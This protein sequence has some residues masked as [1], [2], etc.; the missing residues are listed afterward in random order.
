MASDNSDDEAE[1]TPALIRAAKANNVEGVK[2]ALD[3]GE[4]INVRDEEYYGQ[5]AISWAAELGH[6]EV[7]KILYERDARLDILDFDGNSPI[8]WAKVENNLDVVKY[9][10]ANIK[11]RDVSHKYNHGRGLLFLAVE[12]GSV[13]DIKR[14]VGSEP[15]VVDDDGLTPLMLAASDYPNE[16]ETSKAL[17]EA[18]A[19]PLLEDNKGRTAIFYAFQWVKAELATLLLEKAGSDFNVNGS[20]PGARPLIEAAK[21]GNVTMLQQLLDRKPDVESPDEEGKTP[22]YWSAKNSHIEATCLLIDAGAKPERLCRQPIPNGDW[23]LAAFAIAAT[24]NEERWQR[25][26]RQKPDLTVRNDDNGRT[27]FHHAAY[28]GV[29]TAA[30]ERM[31]SAGYSVDAPDSYGAT[32]LMLASERGHGHLVRLLLDKHADPELAENQWD[33]TALMFAATYGH[34]DIV[35]QLIPK[36]KLDAQD[37]YKNTALH[38]AADRC[39]VESVKA[40]I[41]KDFDIVNVVDDRGESPLFRAVQHNRPEVVAALIKAGADIYLVNRRKRAAITYG[42]N[43]PAI[44]QAFIDEEKD[45]SGPEDKETP[46]VRVIEMAMRYACEDNNMRGPDPHPPIFP[47]DNEEDEKYLTAVDVTGRN[48]VSW[49]AQCGDDWEMRSLCGKKSLDFKTADKTSRTPLHWLAENQSRETVDIA[50]R[51][52]DYGVVL[53]SKDKNGRTPLSYAAE[54]GQLEL[55][56]FLITKGAEPHSED[57]KKRTVLSWAAGSGHD[58]CVQLLLSEKS[59][60][61]DSKDIDGRTPLSW[62]SGMGRIEVVKTLLAQRDGKAKSVDSKDNRGKKEKGSRVMGDE[63]V[64]I[65]S[66]DNKSQTPLWHAADNQHLTVFETLLLYGAKSNIKDTKGRTLRDYLNTKIQGTEVSE[67]QTLRAMF[68]KLN[69]SGFLWREPSGDTT[70]VDSEFSATLL[71][72]SKGDR[73]DIEIRTPTVASLLQ[74]KRPPLEAEMDCAWT[75]LPANNMRWVEVLMSKHFEASGEGWRSNVVL[76]PRLW[77]QQQHKSQDGQYHARFMRP[78][79]RSFTFPEQD[80]ADP[81]LVLFMPYLHWELEEEQRKLKDVMAKKTAAKKLKLSSDDA[82]KE[83]R[84]KLVQTALKD[85]SLCGTEKLYWAYL[86][87]EHPLHGRRTL[88]QFYYHILAD[89]EKRDKDQTSLRYFQE[90]KRALNSSESQDLRPT[91]TVVDQLW[92]WVLPECGKSPRTI[93]T[94]FP[95]RSNRMSKTSKI[96][97]SLV[98]NIFDRFREF[99]AKRSDASVD[100]L[101]KVIVAECAR[102]Y[103]DP[104]SNRNELIQFVEIYRTSI[105]EITEDETKRFQSFQDHIPS[106]DEE[107]SDAVPNQAR[108]SLE[109]SLDVASDGGSLKGSKTLAVD[110]GLDEVPKKLN[111]MIDIKAD[112]E[113]LRKIKDIRDELHIISSIFHIQKNVVETV[114]HILEDFKEKRKSA[115]SD[116]QNSWLP[117]PPRRR[118]FSPPSRRPGYSP[119]ASYPPPPRR[120]SLS[121]PFNGRGPARAYPAR[122]PYSRRPDPD[123]HTYDNTE[124]GQETNQRKYHSTMLEVVN[125]NISE[126]LRL[127]KFAERGAQAIEQLLDLKHKQANLQLTRGIYK[128]NDENDRQGKTIMYFT[129]ATIIFLPLSFMASFLTIEVEEF[130]RVGES[131][132]LSL[133]FVIKI[134]FATSIGVIIP[135]VFLAF[136]LDKRI[137]DQRWNAFLN[138]FKET[139]GF[140][141][142]GTSYGLKASKS[143]MRRRGDRAAKSKQ[144]DPESGDGVTVGGLGHSQRQPAVD[145][146]ADNTDQKGAVA[147]TTVTGTGGVHRRQEAK[148]TSNVGSGTTDGIK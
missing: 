30:L 108:D 147:V 20:R 96:M 48:L 22:L 137:R 130:P 44:I 23:I 26:I 58:D 136:N 99:A 56:R 123:M 19:D 8:Y 106:V 132:N 139:K 42:L 31:I 102:I 53:D 148:A 10:L 118:N 50:V 49:A 59:V 98:S 97:T 71:Y 119:P 128:I 35:E 81:G 57:T 32:P 36:S 5:T 107:L 15:N 27:A 74:G 105:G 144:H 61:P 85:G 4:D 91:I 121:P 65:N 66:R 51:L 79:C 135:S 133:G 138:R 117:P 100:E 38:Y 142:K 90:K 55:M 103:F 70:Q 146:R 92:M 76:K 72:I 52:L 47:L 129:V 141:I 29:E 39:S 28:S 112:I 95:Q 115:G 124:V 33:T 101:A 24:N 104:M 34:D 6:L 37:C 77:E 60:K 3:Q 145:T 78:A 114:D 17:L 88:D 18:G 89:T 40:M 63:G 64:D 110:D 84:Q 12:I 13:E 16:I 122:R 73:L 126:V 67:T 134:I 109:D 127:E 11:E 80:S 116:R 14:F 21:E 143:W 7:V 83:Y 125:R 9:F 45:G 54:K 131:G 120:R 94:A 1:K 140:M 113:D 69:P 62:A 82:T 93:I 46:R 86:D 2:L 68:T 75:H 87:E 41:R 25:F 43:N 111:A